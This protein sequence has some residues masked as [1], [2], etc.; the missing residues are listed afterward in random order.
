MKAV[1]RL[2]AVGALVTASIV[3]THAESVPLGLVL[4]GGGAKGAYEV[5]VWQEQQAVGLAS[6]VT[7]ISATSVGAL[8]AALFATKPEAAEAVK[9]LRKAAEQGYVISQFNLGCSYLVGFHQ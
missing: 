8:N 1:K 5:G 2:F 6:N 9:W 4:S 7:V 3:F